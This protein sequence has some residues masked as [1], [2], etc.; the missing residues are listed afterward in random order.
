MRAS[1]SE[2]PD[3]IVTLISDALFETE[4]IQASGVEVAFHVLSVL[5][6][7]GYPVGDPVIYEEKKAAIQFQLRDMYGVDISDDVRE[8]LLMSELSKIAGIIATAISLPREPWC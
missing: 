2:S 4:K 6:H 3:E 8:Q 1:G 7:A 5:E